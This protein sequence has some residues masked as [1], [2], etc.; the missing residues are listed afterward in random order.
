[1]NNFNI[2]GFGSDSYK[3]SHWPLYPPKTERV[4]SYCEARVG[5]R[6]SEVVFFGLQYIMQEYLSGTVVTREKIEEGAEICEAHFGNTDVFNRKGWEVI[7]NDYDGKL[8][9][10]IRALHEGVVVPEGTPLFSIENTDDRLAWLTN[11]L[12]TIIMQVWSPITVATSSREVKK[13]IDRYLNQTGDPAGIDFKLHDFGYRGVS[14]METAALAGAAHLVNFMGTDTMAAIGLARNHYGEPMAGF[15]IPA[16]EHSIMTARGPEGEADIVRQILATYP[17]G[18]VAMVID[19][20]DTINFIENVIGGNPDIMEAILN[21]EGTVVFRPDSGRLPEIDVEVFR[22]LERVFGSKKNNK[23]FAVLPDQVR[24][25]QGDGIQW[26]GRHLCGTP[27]HTVEDI[28]EAFKE[29]GISADNIAFGSGGGLLQSF[30]RDTQRFAIK[31]SWMQVDGVGRDIFKQPS[32]DPTKNSKR[33]RVCDHLPVVFRNGKL[34]I[35]QTLSEIRERSNAS[36]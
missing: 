14:S 11:Y 19:S 2:C 12:E 36:R 31:C 29:E 6:F 13:I 33:G 3:M 28:L 30:T 16:T 8:P 32:T 21:R 4:Y 22:A 18:L 15:S 20:F 5:G 1:M 27:W 26:K 7:L 17:T 25:I 24:M 34:L 23:G 35:T 9:I 10:E